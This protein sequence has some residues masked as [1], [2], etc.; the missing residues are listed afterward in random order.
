MLEHKT[1]KGKLRLSC[2]ILYILKIREDLMNYQ[3]IYEN[4]VNNAI[5]QNRVKFKKHNEEYVYYENHHII[6]KCLGGEDNQNNLVLLTAREHFM[7]HK[8]LT[9]IYPDNVQ[10]A[11]A[12]NIMVHGNKNKYNVSS[13]DYEYAR[14]LITHIPRTLEQRAK[15]S[16]KNNGMYGKKISEE[17]RKKLKG[18]IPWNKGKKNVYSKETKEKMSISASKRRHS[19]ETKNRMS[20]SVLGPNNPMY[21]RKHSEETKN[22]MRRAIK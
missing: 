18:R 4:L 2:Y 22:K 21:G 16:G 19:K 17:T 20:Q 10:I 12:F 13:R 9:F 3:K 14:N 5:L 8:L 6:P 15:V 1:T 7:C 11:Q